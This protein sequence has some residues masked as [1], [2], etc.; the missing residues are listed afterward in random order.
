MRQDVL[1][2]LLRRA[3]L[4]VVADAPAHLHLGEPLALQLDREREPLVDVD[5]LQHPHLLREA[6]VGRVADGVGERARLGDRADEGRDPAVVA[7]QLEDLLDDRA[8]LP[9]EL[10]RAPVGALVV[11]ALLDLDAQPPA[12]VGLG[13]A[14]ERRGAGR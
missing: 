10:A 14:G 8:V 5:R 3:L 13:G 2:L 12:R 4:D 6:E 7:A 9:L 11:G 1:A